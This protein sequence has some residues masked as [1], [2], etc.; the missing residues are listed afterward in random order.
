MTMNLPK[1]GLLC[2][3][4]VSAFSLGIARAELKWDDTTLE[5]HP[6]FGDKEAV[7]HFKYK[8]TG[9]TPIRFKSVKSSCGCTAAQSQ[10][11]EVK[12]GETGE[13]TATFKIGDRTGLQVK[14]VTVETDDPAHAVTML[15]LKSVLPELLTITPKAVTWAANEEGKPKTISVKAD[16]DFPAKNITV[17]STNNDFTATVDPVKDGEWKI[18]VQPKNTFK[19]MAGALTIKTDV[20]KESPKVF[21]ANMSVMAVPPTAPAS[22]ATH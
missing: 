6:K 2:F 20:P 4:V 17:T 15:T 3:A 16:K 5:L 13:I 22:A 8:N 11:D 10:K 14:T 19:Y 21:Y 9:E 12:P 7:G 1:T 18:T